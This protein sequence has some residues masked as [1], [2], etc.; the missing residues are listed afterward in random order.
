MNEDFDEAKKLKVS[1]D[2]LKSIS[3][4]LGQLE[5]KKRQAIM[6]EDYDAAKLIKIEI[7]KLKDSAMR[8]PPNT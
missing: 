2:R 8:A 6:N 5:E 4:H 7:D 3:S 1:I